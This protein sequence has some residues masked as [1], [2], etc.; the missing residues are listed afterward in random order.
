MSSNYVTVSGVLFAL[1]EVRSPRAYCNATFNNPTDVHIINTDGN[2]IYFRMLTDIKV[3]DTITMKEIASSIIESSANVIWE[4]SVH[5][6]ESTVPNYA[7]TS[8]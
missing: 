7:P 8:T 2:A 5:Y 4:M 3:E 1:E 6:K